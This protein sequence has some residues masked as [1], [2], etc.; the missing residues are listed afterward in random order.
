MD[1]L[2]SNDER[3][4]KVDLGTDRRLDPPTVGETFDPCV[5]GRWGRGLYRGHR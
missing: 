5:R 3:G 1:L 4:Y 2:L